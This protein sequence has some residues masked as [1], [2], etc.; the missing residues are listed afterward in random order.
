MA[1]SCLGL[2]SGLFHEHNRTTR[3]T[4][5]QQLKLDRQDSIHNQYEI[6]ATMSKNIS[7]I[8]SVG[9]WSSLYGGICTFIS[10]LAISPFLFDFD[11]NGGIN[12]LCWF[13]VSLSYLLMTLSNTYIVKT[14]SNVTEAFYSDVASTFATM[15]AC[16]ECVVYY[17]QL[18]YLRRA[19][20]PIGKS[21]IEDETGSPIFALDMLGYFFLSVSSIFVALSL[22]NQDHKL[23][24]YLLFVHGYTGMTCIVVPGLP[25]IYDKDSGEDDVMWQFV[26]L[27]W[28]ALFTPIC[29]FMSNYFGGFEEKQKRA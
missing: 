14:H 12:Y 22:K 29:F 26:I 13:M 20:D 19:T 9:K 6:T 1:F 10:A 27:F 15:Y 2:C 3:S 17:L 21:L 16:Y 23:L 11:S 8:A 18:T 24:K 25:M 5:H 7:A 4:K 28:S